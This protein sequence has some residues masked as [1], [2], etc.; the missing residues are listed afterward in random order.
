MNV[1]VAAGTAIYVNFT[2]VFKHVH[3]YCFKHFNM[4]MVF[5]LFVPTALSWFKKN[6]VS[7][8]SVTFLCIKVIYLYIIVY[9]LSSCSW[10]IS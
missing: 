8:E 6:Y 3:N 4:L 5:P 10:I 1:N 2:P 7:F 9:Y